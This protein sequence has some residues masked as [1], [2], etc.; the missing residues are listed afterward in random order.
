MRGARDRI[1]PLFGPTGHSLRGRRETAIEMRRPVASPLAQQAV[2]DAKVI[3][4]TDE[5][6]EF[7]G[8]QVVA[9]RR[10]MA[11]VAAHPDE[12]SV[13]AL[14]GDPDSHDSTPA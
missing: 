5:P 13:A 2:R 12:E 6:A 9:G 3:V 11:A 8:R 10:T 7:G 1:A 14:V 4:P